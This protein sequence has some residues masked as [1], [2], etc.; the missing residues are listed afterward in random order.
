MP[1]IH[2][3]WKKT[4]TVCFCAHALLLSDVVIPQLLK[5]SPASACSEFCVCNWTV[6]HTRPQRSFKVRI[7]TLLLKESALTNTHLTAKV[8]LD[9][10]NS[11]LN[12]TEL[13][14]SYK[15]LV[16]SSP[17]LLPA[18][19]NYHGGV[20][21]FKDASFSWSDDPSDGSMTPTRRS[22]NL[23]VS[24]AMF[25]KPNSINMVIGPT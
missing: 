21:G 10:V 17:D 6:Y 8:S 3:S 22:F 20:I 18:N 23:R 19:Q 9:R 5:Y 16:S 11:F 25:F 15:A 13:L 2:S 24:G 4:S 14:D 1:H 7:G 12:E